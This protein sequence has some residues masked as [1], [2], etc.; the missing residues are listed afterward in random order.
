MSRSLNQVFMIGNLTRDPETRALQDGT[1]VCRFSLALNRAYTTP[2][3]ETRE[4]VSYVDVTA[5]R[6][7][8][9]VVQNYCHKGKQVMVQGRLKSSS[10]EQDGQ[11][12]SKLEVEAENLIL[13][14]GPGGGEQAGSA[15]PRKK[16]SAKSGQAEEDY[17]SEEEYSQEDVN[18]ED[19]PF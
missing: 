7:L 9:T 15:G 12:R 18:P 6:G 13:L 3:G 4:S 14:G 1:E 10:W 16:A 19:V 5:W 8:A 17:E 2:D 11:T